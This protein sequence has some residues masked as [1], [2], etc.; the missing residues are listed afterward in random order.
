MFVDDAGTQAKHTFAC[1]V[2]R[3]QRRA[4]CVAEMFG[5]RIASI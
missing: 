4:T 2:L 1:R 3:E 5:H